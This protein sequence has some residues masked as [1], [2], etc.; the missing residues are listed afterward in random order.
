MHTFRHILYRQIDQENNVIFSIL[1]ITGRIFKIV[2]IKLIEPK[3]DDT[4]PKCNEKITKSTET[5]S[6]PIFKDNGGYTVYSVPA[7]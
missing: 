5:P 3:I 4:P 7:P 1:I 2:V 6:C